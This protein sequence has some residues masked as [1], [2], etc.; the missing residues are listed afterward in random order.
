MLRFQIVAGQDAKMTFHP[1]G[2]LGG[3]QKRSCELKR[4]ESMVGDLTGMP[5]PVLARFL[6]QNE[7]LRPLQ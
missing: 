4:V 7:A 1:S 5:V 3:P 2:R 6:C